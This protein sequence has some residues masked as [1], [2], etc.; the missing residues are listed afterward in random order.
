MTDKTLRNALVAI[1]RE[2][3]RD[4]ADYDYISARVSFRLNLR[5]QFY[6]SAL[7]ATEKYLKAIL[8]F[9]QQKV[10]DLRHYVVK[11]I[12]RIKE[13]THV[14]L[15]LDEGQL[16]FLGVLE[17]FG[18]NR[19]GTRYTRIIGYELP[20]LDQLIWTIRH[21]AHSPSL[22]VDGVDKSE[23]Y[24]QNLRPPNI[25]DTATSNQISDG[26]LEKILSQSDTDSLRQELIWC[27]RYYGRPENAL[28]L[29]ARVHSSSHTPVYERDWFTKT[30]VE[31]GKTLAKAVQDFV[32][33]P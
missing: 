26:E 2:G 15:M 19:Y 9:N 33:F 24:L 7:Q 27:N 8:L 21:Y 13:N 6:W 11:A 20:K 29:P 25:A 22:E 4:L 1:A 3:F 31:S 18:N 23:W 14:P 28:Q 30:K 17:E 10:K 16:Q 32:K 12:K 5:E